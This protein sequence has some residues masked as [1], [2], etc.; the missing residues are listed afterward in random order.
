MRMICL[1]LLILSAGCT[2]HEESPPIPETANTGDPALDARINRLI[3]QLSEEDPANRDVALEELKRIGE[4]ALEALK[5]ATEAK[6]TEEARIPVE[7]PTP[8]P[9][10]PLKPDLDAIQHKLDTLRVEATLE[11]AS[12]EE[13]L[14]LLGLLA[15]VPFH[16]DPEVPEQVQK[17]NLNIKDILL[18]DA[19]K[20]LL[21][22]RDLNYELTQVGVIRILVR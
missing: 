9:T 20:L 17:V 15:D 3:R 6:K 1:T 4:P 19:L 18:K 11:E 12:L 8:P 7:A 14:D 16:I 21:E 2:S 22:P 13:A 10:D 5:R